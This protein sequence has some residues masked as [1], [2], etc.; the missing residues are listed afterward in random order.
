VAM[1]PE[2]SPKH[3]AKRYRLVGGKSRHQQG[4]NQGNFDKELHG[5]KSKGIFF[6]V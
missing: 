3:T 5:G 2:G 6:E 4:T 1:V